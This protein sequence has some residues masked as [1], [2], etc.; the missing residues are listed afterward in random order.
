MLLLLQLLQLL[1]LLLLPM[2][3]QH[4]LP[5]STPPCLLEVVSVVAPEPLTALHHTT[6]QQRSPRVATVCYSALLCCYA[7]RAK[8]RSNQQQDHCRPWDPHAVKYH[9]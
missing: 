3:L 8:C 7:V 6:E 1:L 9:Q 4:P 5:D 2:L